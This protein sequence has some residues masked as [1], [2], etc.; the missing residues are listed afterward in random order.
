MNTTWYAFHEGY[1]YWVSVLDSPE[2]ME[3]T[4]DTTSRFVGGGYT[5]AISRRSFDDHDF[6]EK[7]RSLFGRTDLHEMM[8]VARALEELPRERGL[9]AKELRKR[10]DQAGFE[11]FLRLEECAKDKES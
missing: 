5:E 8:A 6:R 9:P 7:M 11:E 1:Q 4:C 2:R 3:F 10:R